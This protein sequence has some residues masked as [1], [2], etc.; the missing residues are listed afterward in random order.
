MPQDR[1]ED[2][3]IVWSTVVRRERPRYAGVGAVAVLWVTVIVGMR[4]V[5]LGW[6]DDRPVSYLGDDPATRTLFRAGLLAA[7]VL[8]VVFAICLDRRHRVGRGFLAAFLVGQAGQVVVALVPLDGPGAAR[9]VHTTAGIV[10]GLS[11]PVLMWRLAAGEVPWPTAAWVLTG[12]EVAACAVG[13]GLSR[14]MRAPIAEIVP[15]LGFHLWVAVVTAMPTGSA[16]HLARSEA[17]GRNRRA[18]AE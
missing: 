17:R 15:A 16:D 14:S 8:F 2:Q 10:L 11:L 18:Q 4:R 3:G 1:W 9:A 5:G 12:L 6:S 7:A 13:V